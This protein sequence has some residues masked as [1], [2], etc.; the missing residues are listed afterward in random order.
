PE[1]CNDPM[2]DL[3]LLVAVAL[4]QL[5]VLGATG[6]GDLRIHVATILHQRLIINHPKSRDV[7]QQNFPEIDPSTLGIPLFC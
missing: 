3:A 7:P 1:V 5:K 6:S 2:A 4:D